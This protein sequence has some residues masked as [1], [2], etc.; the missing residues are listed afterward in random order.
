MAEEAELFILVQ[1]VMQE[2]LALVRSCRPA[3]VTEPIDK[4]NTPAE[5]VVMDLAVI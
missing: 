2:V 3:V 4:I 5:L 1:A